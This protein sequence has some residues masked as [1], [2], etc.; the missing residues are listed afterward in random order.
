MLEVPCFDACHHVLRTL[1]YADHTLCLTPAHTPL[2]VTTPFAPHLPHCLTDSL[3]TLHTL[4]PL[5]PHRS[6]PLH[7]LPF[8]HILL[9]RLSPQRP[10][11]PVLIACA[12]TLHTLTTLTTH[13][14]SVLPSLGR[15]HAFLLFKDR[16]EAQ[17]ALQQLTLQPLTL[18]KDARGREAMQ[19]TSVLTAR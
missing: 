16:E 15:G 12:P 5:L 8:L 6:S 11:P 3:H 13:L 10:L 18:G 1:T 2:L 9:P 7:P 4:G 14:H 19:V 17:S